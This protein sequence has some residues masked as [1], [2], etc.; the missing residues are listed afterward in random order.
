M[1]GIHQSKTCFLNVSVNTRKDEKEKYFS[2]FHFF[3]VFLW[4]SKHGLKAVVITVV[5]T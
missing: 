1:R 4:I 3:G 5:V 2:Y